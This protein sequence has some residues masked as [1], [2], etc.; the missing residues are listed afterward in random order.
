M[1]NKKLF[2]FIF[3]LFF[4]NIYANKNYNHQSQYGFSPFVVSLGGISSPL[5]D[6]FKAVADNPATSAVTL[7]ENISFNTS[8]ITGN[9][10]Y[11]K[12]PFI[13]SM[14]IPWGVLSVTENFVLLPSLSNNF[15]G[16]LSSTQLIFAKDLT[17][18]IY[19]GVAV[20]FDVSHIESS[21]K[22]NLNQTSLSGI[23]L[24]MAVNGR[25]TMKPTKKNFDLFDFK[26]G[27]SLKNIGWIPA[28]ELDSDQK[29]Y[30]KSMMIKVG[31][32]S[33]FVKLPIAKQKLETRFL[34]EIN[35]SL[36]N[37]NFSPDFYFSSALSFSLFLTESTSFEKIH[38]NLGT[39]IKPIRDNK[40]IS[41]FSGLGT[42]FKLM[43]LLFQVDYAISVDEN[44]G[45]YIGLNMVFGQKDDAP[46]EVEID[47]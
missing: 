41:F 19:F 46:P 26:Y 5:F 13:F 2:F 36:P 12:L 17:D 38:F 47:F 29:I 25:L 14:P 44:I 45:H 22:N 27:I 10:G 7:R 34:F 31:I 9:K 23:N 15:S 24:D 40:Q 11:T 37:D 33:L 39:Q 8:F 18:D 20:N 21:E 30:Y 35:S 1:N 43:S 16:W 3:S 6:E 42:S 32:S 28:V 4:F